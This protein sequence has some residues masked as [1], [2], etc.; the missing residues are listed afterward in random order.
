[1][2]IP[3]YAKPIK[4]GGV[5]DVRHVVA[6]L[7]KWI[8]WMP[9]ESLNWGGAVEN[10]KF[11]LEQ[12]GEVKQGCEP[13]CFSTLGYKVAFCYDAARFTKWVLKARHG[14]QGVTGSFE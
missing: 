1:V 9:L 5:G 3:Q 11:D 14:F 7:K 10:Q 13:H 6:L 4:P 2:C 8:S 12:F